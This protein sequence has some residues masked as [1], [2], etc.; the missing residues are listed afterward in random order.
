MI[1]TM[2]ADQ[3]NYDNIILHEP[4][5]NQIFNDSTFTRILYSN[6]MITTGG[7]HLRLDIKGASMERRFNKTS[8]QFNIYNNAELIEKMKNIEQSILSMINNKN[9]VKGLHSELISGRIVVHEHSDLVVIKIS[10]IWE[11]ETNCGLTYKFL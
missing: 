2:N 8:I 10:G 6:H 4:V 3:F 7:I 1:L 11:T 9:H 5:K